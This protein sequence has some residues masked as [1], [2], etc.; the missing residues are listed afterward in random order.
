M[1]DKHTIPIEA[2]VPG[3]IKP[4]DFVHVFTDDGTCSRCREPESEDEVPLLLWVGEGHLM[5]R[6]CHKCTGQDTDP[7][8]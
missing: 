5:Y 8:G 1:S 7:G 6:F 4:T 3:G 2:M